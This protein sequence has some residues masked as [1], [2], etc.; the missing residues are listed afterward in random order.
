MLKMDTRGV[1]LAFVRE[2]QDKSRRSRPKG[3]RVGK[4]NVWRDEDGKIWVP[5][6]AKELKNALYAVAHQG[7]HLHRGY[8]A[9][10][11]RLHKFAMAMAN[12]ATE[13]K[14]SSETLENISRMS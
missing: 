3:L 13:Q 14:L 12:E 11:R 4:G 9:V 8:I 5:K 1:N 2:Q 6:R 10:S 7:P